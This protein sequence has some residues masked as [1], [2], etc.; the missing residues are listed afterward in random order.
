MTQPQ[1][2][3]LSGLFVPH[4]FLEM[5]HACAT[6]CHASAGKETTVEDLPKAVQLRTPLRGSTHQLLEESPEFSTSIKM[7]RAESML[8]LDSPWPRCQDL[9][10]S[11]FKSPTVDDFV[12]AVSHGWPYQTHPDPL[13]N[14]A[15]EVRN[16]LKE[17]LA[18]HRP[19][20]VA[21]GFYDFTSV[22][23]RPFLEGQADRTQRQ[24]ESF[25]EALACMPKVYLL[26]DAVLH[27]DVPWMPVPGGR[28]LAAR[29]RLPSCRVPPSRKWVHN[30]QVS[31]LS[32]EVSGGD[33]RPR[34]F[35]NRGGD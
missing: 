20:G 14:C 30:V 22:T 35:D 2:L 23:Q 6:C 5:G 19:L 3:F 8:A 15:A 12:F 18:V 1:D 25:K 34:I 7:M 11:A 24:S 4:N 26:A 16:L 29:R 32:G 17:A 21:V 31:K 28:R 9:P 33:P 27:V 10:D 13:G